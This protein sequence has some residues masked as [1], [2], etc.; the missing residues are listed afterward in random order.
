MK[1]GFASHHWTDEQGRPAGGVTYGT[2]FAISWQHG[3]LGR[4]PDRKAPNGAFVEDVL[5]AVIDRI[6][7]YQQSEFACS[8]NDEAL[9]Y[10]RSAAEHL[11]NRTKDR[12]ARQVEG[13]HGR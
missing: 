11:D 4:G 9:D 8:E 13:T 2:G 3:P 10:L 7:C 6:E 5:A 12:E 1:I